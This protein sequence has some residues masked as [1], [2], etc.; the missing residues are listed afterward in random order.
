ML[1]EQK[2]ENTPLMTNTLSQLLETI[3]LRAGDSPKESY[4]AKLLK[5]GIP[6]IAKKLGE[7]GVECA[8]AAV[9][10]DRDEIVYEA[11]DMLYHLLVLLHAKDIP[12]HEIL[13]ELERRMGTSGITEKQNRK[14]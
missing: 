12:L 5:K 7:E 1:T 8:L 2:S 11:A 3:A 10:N 14:K 4:T 6:H 9:Q 13:A